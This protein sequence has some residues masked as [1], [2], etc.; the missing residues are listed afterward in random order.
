M[1]IRFSKFRF[2]LHWHLLVRRYR[3]RVRVRP[4][5]FQRRQKVVA[6]LDADEGPDMWKETRRVGAP[7]PRCT[8][9]IMSGP[10][11]IG[12]SAILPLSPIAW[13]TLDL[14]AWTSVCNEFLSTSSRKSNRIFS[15]S[16]RRG[17]LSVDRI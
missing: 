6:E 1:G 15:S 7:C 9:V 2:N 3:Q 10:D 13:K 14:D 8:F 11:N 17:R 12:V 4:E 5:P 16:K